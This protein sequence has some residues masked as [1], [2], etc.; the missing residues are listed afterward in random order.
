MNP[1]IKRFAGCCLA[2]L[3]AL[4]LAAQ[5]ALTRVEYYLDT[6]PGYGSATAISFSP[7]ATNLS[8]IAI[9]IDPVTLSAGV[10]VLGIRAKDANNAW[11][12][13]NKWLFVKPYNNSVAIPN[14]SRIEYYLDTDPGYGN[15]T[16][17]SIGTGNNFANL[18]VNID[19][20]TLSAGVHVF[21][22]RAKDANGAWSLDNKWLFVKPYSNSN[23]LP[24]LTTVEYY[25]DTDPGYGSAT[26][27]SIGA[28]TDFAN[29][30]VNIDPAT[31]A[32]GV[33]LV[34]IRAKDANG[35]W[36]LD[37]KWLF[38]KPSHQDSAAVPNLKVVEYYFDT[39][40]GYGNGV[41][42]A[43]N[44]VTNISNYSMPVNISGLTA[45]NHNLFIRSKDVNNAWSLDNVFAFTVSAA[46][47][48][49][50]VVVNSITKKSLCE[51]DALSVSYQA[52]GTYNAGNVFNV[53]MSNAS[54]SFAS[55][56]IIGS[57][58]G[59]GNKIVPC[60]LPAGITAGSAYRVRVSAT[61]P[62]VTGITGSDVLTVSALPPT[63]TITAGGAT[64][65]CQ[66]GS[67]TLTSSVAA[68]YAWSTGATT[69]SI[70]V[71][72]S[73]SYTVTVANSNGCSATS[74]ATAVT[75]NPKPAPVITPSGATTICSGS[76][77][78]LDAGAGYSS[79][80]W[81]TG[82]TTQTITVS[83]AGNYTVAV[84]SSSGCS[85]TSAATTV[86]VV[87][88]PT[89]TT[90][91][92]GTVSIPAG[93][94][95]TITTNDT[96]AA[97]LWSTGATTQSI[98]A[99]AAGSYT[100]T[101][102]NGTGCSG[103]S[104][105]VVVTISSCP[106][107]TITASGSVTNVCAGKK[108]TLTA[109]AGSSYL[110][111]TG[112]TTQKITVT[113]A[114]SYYV[115]E[116]SACGNVTSDTTV[117]TYQTCANP[118]GLVAS[119]ITAS[120]ATLGWTGVPCATKYNVEYKKSGT[121][122]WTTV[123]A[124]GTSTTV[125]GLTAN[126]TYNWRVQTVCTTPKSGYTNGTNFKTTAG[127]V[128]DNTGINLKMQGAFT[129]LVYPNPAAGKATIHV[130]GAL[131]P[132]TATLA[133]MAGRVLWKSQATQGMD[134]NLPVATLSAGVY[135]VTVTDGLEIRIIK[136]VKE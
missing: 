58:T 118:T 59:T 62:V 4:C 130:T 99:T 76:S 13:D 30:T 1:I 92:S 90:T 65:F 82:A 73:G 36:S 71:S 134:I 80:A 35:A 133:D 86:T 135:M 57:F 123:V 108:I 77:V 42:V 79:Y 24:N 19:P 96:Y 136:L 101:V 61:N 111:S 113:A 37:N 46:V 107:P 55:P 129:A 78:T 11:S 93:G 12:L 131:Q 132:V 28:G 117:V 109:S 119:G 88:N 103:T 68:S 75:V 87:A 56:T 16:S 122:T 34:G 126:T 3:W 121:T 120:S 105:P 53:E 26:N 21:G 52:N 114:G 89:P 43:I 83:A 8:N 125:T 112:A 39:D 22:I 94:N 32:S 14:V 66:G 84:T 6:D 124:T 81:S 17:V 45:G 67:V 100:V 23:T 31:L 110:W 69:Q 27:V 15:A 74:A 72:A 9:N 63:P 7:G 18:A 54:G 91:P 95:V 10:H 106:K 128:A 116:P 38:V 127:P 98:N 50:S 64:T 85:G 49:P 5:P 44:N 20:A 51:K 104:A 115:T 97:Y 33:H 29:L 102:T 40:P 47:A 2:L 48:N 41:P 60:V 25:I 70:T